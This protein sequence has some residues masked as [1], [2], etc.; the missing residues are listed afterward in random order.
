MMFRRVARAW[1]F[2]RI[3]ASTLLAYARI[4]HFVVSERLWTL[5]QR[6]RRAVGVT[7]SSSRR[8]LP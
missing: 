8:V 5:P 2:A 3:V 6:Q 7:F 1:T 4:V